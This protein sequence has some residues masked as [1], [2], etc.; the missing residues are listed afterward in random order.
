MVILL[1]HI[2]SDAIL[3][4]NLSGS[5]GS[6]TA[7]IS[8]FF[9]LFFCRLL[10]TQDYIYFVQ[11]K[12]T[13]LEKYHKKWKKLAKHQSKYL[14]TTDAN[15]IKDAAQILSD[16]YDLEKLDR[17]EAKKCSLCQE[18]SK[19][20]CSRCKEVWYCSRYTWNTLRICLQL[21]TLD[22]FKTN[23]VVIIS[24]LVESVK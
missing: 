5:C 8:L 19:K 7:G 6:Y 20:R 9:K 13:I 22:A 24:S 3:K 17:I 4:L 18:L 15:Y 21:V 2:A 23:L 14:F 10:I 12:T 11:I 16:V 1:K